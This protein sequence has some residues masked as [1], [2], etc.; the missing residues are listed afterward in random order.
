VSWGAHF[1]VSSAVPLN[2]S[3]NV[4]DHVPLGAATG[5][6]VRAHP[7][8][9]FSSGMLGAV[10]PGASYAFA[11]LVVVVEPPAEPEVL[12]PV[13]VDVVDG[14]EPL[15]VDGVVPTDPVGLVVVVV[16]LHA[17]SRCSSG[18]QVDVVAPTR[19]NETFSVAMVDERDRAGDP[20]ATTIT[21][22][23]RMTRIASAVRKIR[24]G[25]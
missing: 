12:V 3:S 21:D 4:Q 2:S 23:K 11:G 20:A 14:D 22:A 1:V 25:W 5:G 8:L 6:A 17:P 16:V 7:L 13:V 24:R 10:A 18:P 19:S 15:V 9:A